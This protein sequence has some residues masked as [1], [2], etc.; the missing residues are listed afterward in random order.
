MTKR[1][2][3]TVIDQSDATWHWDKRVPIAMIITMVLSIGG[4]GF[5]ATWFFSK[6]DS[7]VETLEKA[8]ATA[9]P[10][11]ANQGERLIRVEENLKGVK[12]GITEIKA[13]LTAQDLRDRSGK[14]TR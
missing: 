8:A 6:M 1:K 9:G 14:V 10:Q 12:D 3:E 5:L 11:T 13:I 4:Q 7:R 2:P